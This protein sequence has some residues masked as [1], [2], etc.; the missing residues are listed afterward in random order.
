MKNIILIVASLFVGIFSS[1]NASTRSIDDQ[2]IRLDLTSLCTI[3]GQV[4]LTLT[5]T[6]GQKL[7]VDPHVADSAL[8]DAARAMFLNRV[9]DL[10]LVGL[11]PLTEYV[12]T[13]DWNV[14][15]AGGVISYPIDFTKYAVVDT[16]K[17]YKAGAE[18]RIQILLE[19]GKKV[20]VLVDSAILN[21]FVEVEPSCFK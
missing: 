8:F 11:R 16:T 12:R 9:D 1:A 18:I 3:D 17:D 7:F 14:L 6:S 15:A 13:S 10:S 5:N 2:Y 4:T 20:V 19:N 21:K